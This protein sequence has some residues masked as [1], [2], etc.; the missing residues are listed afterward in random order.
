M[1]PS[2]FNII[3]ILHFL[4]LLY[5]S[6]VGATGEEEVVPSLGQHGLCGVAVAL[7]HAEGALVAAQSG[8]SEWPVSCN[9]CE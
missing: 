1:I 3:I 8:Q 4:S 5:L 2:I 7:D 6:D 9:G